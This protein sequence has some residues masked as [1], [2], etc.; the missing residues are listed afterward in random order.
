M[1]FEVSDLYNFS[2]AACVTKEA[3]SS[4]NT[5]LD[6]MML[7]LS[8]LLYRYLHKERVKVWCEVNRLLAKSLQDLQGIYCSMHI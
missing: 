4:L 6:V 7:L 5:C 2:F 1:R 8:A 3:H